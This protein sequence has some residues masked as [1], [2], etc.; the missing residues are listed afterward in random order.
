MY[1]TAEIRGKIIFDVK[2]LN[3]RGS[4]IKN[5]TCETSKMNVYF[6]ITIQVSEKRPLKLQPYGA[7]Q[8]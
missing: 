8:I 5:F 4:S 1:K 6:S 2:S 3:L 7:L